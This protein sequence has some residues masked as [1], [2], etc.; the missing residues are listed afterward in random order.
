MAVID[1]QRGLRIRLFRR[2]HPQVEQRTYAADLPTRLL[3]IDQFRFEARE[4][5]LR[6][7]AEQRVVRTQRLLPIQLRPRQ[8]LQ[9]FLVLAGEAEGGHAERGRGLLVH[10]LQPRR[11]GVAP[12][13]QLLHAGTLHPVE[14]ALEQLVAVAVAA[15][16]LAPRLGDIA[17]TVRL[18]GELGRNLL[19]LPVPVLVLPVE[20][21]E[22][23]IGTTAAGTDVAGPAVHRIAEA[24]QAAHRAHR[25]HRAEAARTRRRRACRIAPHVPVTARKR[26]EVVAVVCHLGS[27]AAEACMLATHW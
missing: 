8:P 11:R 1:R 7:L 3:A 4:R 2:I 6:D 17:R 5:I 20:M 27:S 23:V 10:R 24:L 15:D 12:L 9:T 21:P 16:Q 26:L 13:L 22:H 14:Q 18:A 25:A 19:H